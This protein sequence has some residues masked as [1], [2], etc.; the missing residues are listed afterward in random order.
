MLEQVICDDACR[1]CIDIAVE[2]SDACA[3]ERQVCA[4]KDKIR[5][6]GEYRRRKYEKMTIYM[7]YRPRRR[8]SGECPVSTL[9]S[10]R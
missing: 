10:V 2:G 8:P 3:Q 7:L 5:Q 1:T 4:Q 9:E 6:V